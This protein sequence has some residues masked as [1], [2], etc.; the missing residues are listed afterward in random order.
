MKVLKFRTIKDNVVTIILAH[1]M[2][3]DYSE[4]QRELTLT[5]VNVKEIGIYTR[6]TSLT[7]FGSSIFNNT[8]AYE[9]TLEVF[10]RVLDEV[11]SYFN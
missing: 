5:L 1:V 6:D 3:V 2:L 8:P 7:Y 9:V 4:G 10:N 11:A